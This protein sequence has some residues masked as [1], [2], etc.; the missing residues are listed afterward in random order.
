M[1]VHDKLIA[2]GATEISPTIEYGTQEGL[3]SNGL[4]V[5][6]VAYTGSSLASTIVFIAVMEHAL[7]HQSVYPFPE[8]RVAL[9]IF[10]EIRQHCGDFTVKCL[11]ILRVTHPNRDVGV[12]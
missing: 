8:G 5:P 4:W 12:A 3:E 2:Q 9:G 7:L 10:V 11:D 6:P 1:V